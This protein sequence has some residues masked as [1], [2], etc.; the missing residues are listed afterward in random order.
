L[1]GGRLDSVIEESERARK[2]L[3]ESNDAGGTSRGVF[4][5][6][7]TVK[8]T[9]AGQGKEADDLKVC[10]QSLLNALISR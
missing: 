6:A 8:E 7:E 2:K 5:L 4:R 9:W 3:K 10:L 1:T